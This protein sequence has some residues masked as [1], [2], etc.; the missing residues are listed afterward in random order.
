MAKGAPGQ[1]GKSKYQE[2][3]L[4]SPRATSLLQMP[5]GPQGQGAGEI[6]GG[7]IG[8]FR[9]LLVSEIFFK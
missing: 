2:N 6:G 4:P 8:S 5:P 7:D 3:P 1:P 9:L